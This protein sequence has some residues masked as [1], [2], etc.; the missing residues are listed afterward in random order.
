MNDDNKISV[1]KLFE[2]LQVVYRQN[3]RKAMFTL[4]LYMLLQAVILTFS[5]LSMFTVFS[6]ESI[7]GNIVTLVILFIALTVCFVL[8]YGMTITIT[9]LI[10]KKFVTIGYLFSGFKRDRRVIPCALILSGIVFAVGIISSVIIVQYNLHNQ[11]V[12]TAEEFAGK[13]FMISLILLAVIA[14]LLLPFVFVWMYLYVDSNMKVFTAFKKSAGM[15]FRNF[16]KFIGFEVLAA[17]FYFAVTVIVSIMSGKLEAVAGDKVQFV[18]MILSAV[19][20]VTEYL[21]LVRLFFG[22]PLFFFSEIGAI[23]INQPGMKEENKEETKPFMIGSDDEQNSSSEK[24][25][26]EN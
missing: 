23:E 24:E 10:E 6:S 4:V 14:L 25:G 20:I 12:V 17:G 15:L 3:R 5:M 18:C 26:D 9:R 11:V 13:S 1:M 7:P 16:F 19:A 22:V 8:G 2:L 21:G